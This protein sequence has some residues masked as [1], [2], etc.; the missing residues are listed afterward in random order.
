[1]SLIFITLLVCFVISLFFGRFRIE[2]YLRYTTVRRHARKGTRNGVR[3]HS[4]RISDG[5]RWVWVPHDA[6]KKKINNQCT[7]V[8]YGN[9]PDISLKSFEKAK[10]THGS[11]LAEIVKSEFSSVDSDIGHASKE[12]PISASIAN[13]YKI[14]TH[15]VENKLIH[16]E[17]EQNPF[18]TRANDSVIK[19]KKP[20]RRSDE[21]IDEYQ[22]RV[23]EW[24]DLYN[25]SLDEIMNVRDYDQRLKRRIFGQ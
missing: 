3:K 5:T 8:V 18:D 22:Q 25:A 24:D 15:K 13:K 6:T 20:I 21:T 16:V 4:R 23:L 14:P 1:M 19:P 2:R 12:L 7:R 11:I 10:N 17:S 9:D